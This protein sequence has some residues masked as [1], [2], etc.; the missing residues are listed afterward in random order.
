MTDGAKALQHRIDSSFVCEERIKF[1]GDNA[2]E[3]GDRY[4]SNNDYRPAPEN[5]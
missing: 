4:I 2:S 1:D 5:Q 3:I